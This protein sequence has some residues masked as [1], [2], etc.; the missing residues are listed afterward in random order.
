MGVELV[1]CSLTTTSLSLRLR[2]LI[3]HFIMA[4]LAGTCHFSFHWSLIWDF[5][6][7]IIFSSWLSSYVFPD[8]RSVS[9]LPTCLQF[10]FYTCYISWSL[11]SLL[12]SGLHF[13]FLHYQFVQPFIRMNEPLKT[14]VTFCEHSQPVIS[15]HTTMSVS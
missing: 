2:G 13:F 14:V 11:E 1:W 3:P 9:F 12:G 8:S 10:L 4:S 7:L 6:F 5:K 15:M